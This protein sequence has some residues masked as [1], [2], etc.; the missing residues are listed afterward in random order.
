MH[1]AQ[2]ESTGFLTAGVNTAGTSAFEPGVVYSGLTV[3]AFAEDGAEVGM[4]AEIPGEFDLGSG[5]VFDADDTQVFHQ[6]FN[7]Y[8]AL[9]KLLHGKQYISISLKLMGVIVRGLAY[10]TC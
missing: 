3:T 9:T 6:S 7:I 1:D 2:V 10:S 4:S 8:A 5:S